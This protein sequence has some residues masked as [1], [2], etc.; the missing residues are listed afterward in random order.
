MIKISDVW[1]EE[2]IQSLKAAGAREVICPIC[3]N[4]T[5]NNWTIC[6]HCDWEYDDTLKGYSDANRAYIGW[7]RLRYQFKKR[8]KAGR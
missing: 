1:P 5:L 4:E 3:K 2:E 8:F 6:P 7:Y